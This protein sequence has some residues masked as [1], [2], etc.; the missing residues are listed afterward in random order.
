MPIPNERFPKIVPNAAPK[1]IPRHI[2]IE[3]AELSFPPILPIV[4]SATIV[5]PQIITFTQRSFIAATSFSSSIISYI[6]ILSFAFNSS[7]IN[8]SSN[9]YA[10]AVCFCS[11]YFFLDFSVPNLS[12]KASSTWIALSIITVPISFVA[13]DFPSISNSNSLARCFSYLTI[14]M[15]HTSFFLQIKYTFPL[16]LSTATI[17]FF[18]SSLEICC[19]SSLAKTNLSFWTFL[20]E[21]LL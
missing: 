8:K 17:F 16:L 10:L 9:T 13:L 11:V 7:D 14:T 20:S 2:P 5:S 21:T 4:L 18:N 1:H 12:C 3:I 15:P 19:S 6:M